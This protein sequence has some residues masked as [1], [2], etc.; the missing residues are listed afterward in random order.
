M[1]E[2]P[3]VDLG[4]HREIQPGMVFA[5]MPALY[6]PDLGGFALADTVSVT[7]SGAERLN[8]LPYELDW[9]TLQA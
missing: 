7:E 2:P 4:D 8:G 5:L 3:F 1:H 6:V 9:L